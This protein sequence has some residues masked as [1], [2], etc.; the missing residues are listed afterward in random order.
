MAKPVLPASPSG[1]SLEAAADAFIRAARALAPVTGPRA[2]RLIFGLDATASRQ[3]TWDEAAEIQAEMFEVATGLGGLEIQLAHYGG[4]G[5]AATPFLDRADALKAAMYGVRCAAG[6]TRIGR[7]FDH[8]A[9]IGGP[10]GVTALVFVG[11]AV[12]EPPA[13]LERAA[14]RLALLGIPAFL[15]HE[16]R[17]S[18][19]AA[20]FDR[21]ARLT[22]GAACRFDRTSAGELLALLRAVATYAAGGRAALTA[23][24]ARAEADGAGARRLIAGW[25]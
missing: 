9:A 7:L 24:A 4:G 3:A 14:G 12:E 6:R 5:F 21:L 1:S 8:A 11:D 17:D 15:F 16:G 22:G 10:E 20:I 25:R 23:L 2:P 18:R 19:A 13:D